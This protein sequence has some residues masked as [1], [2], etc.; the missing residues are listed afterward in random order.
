MIITAAVA[1]SAAAA[2]IA[3]SVV[4][5]KPVGFDT[6][7][8]YG[9]HAAAIADAMR[10]PH[11]PTMHGFHEQVGC[12]L[13]GYTMIVT[14]FPDRTTEDTALATAT[15]RQWVATGNGWVVGAETP[16]TVTTGRALAQIIV[17]RIGG[18]TALLHAGK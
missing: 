14:T 3:S 16:T 18:K 8:T 7:R 6:P 13:N 15:D 4:F 9:V 5:D 1:A 2:I 11:G 12:V 10:C 17:S